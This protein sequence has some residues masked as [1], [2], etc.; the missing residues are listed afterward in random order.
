MLRKGYEHMRTFARHT[1]HAV[2]IGRQIHRVL[3]PFIDSY[4]GTSHRK[5]IEDALQSYNTLRSEVLRH[6]D[7]AH[8]ALAA[9]RRIP[10]LGL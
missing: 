10:N 9:V 1:D 8:S 3:T 6:D 5:P 4:V 2:N 7:N